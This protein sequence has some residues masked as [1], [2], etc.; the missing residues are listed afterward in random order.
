MSLFLILT[1][2]SQKS[3]RLPKKS[4]LKKDNTNIPQNQCAYFKRILIVFLILSA[5]LNSTR[6]RDNFRKT[7]GMASLL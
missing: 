6:D 1:R 2:V 7:F 5:I 3:N 4:Y